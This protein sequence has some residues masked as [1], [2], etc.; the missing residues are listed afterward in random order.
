MKFVKFLTSD[1]QENHNF[2]KIREAVS[3]WKKF[4]YTE[5]TFYF[6]QKMGVVFWDKKFTNSW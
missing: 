4:T 2:T 3:R 6:Y 5:R 1:S